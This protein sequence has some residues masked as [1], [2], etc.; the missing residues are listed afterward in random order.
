MMKPPYEVIRELESTN[1]RLDKEAI[2]RREAQAENSELF[3]GLRLALDPLMPFNVKKVGTKESDSREGNLPQE[4]FN[5]LCVDL[6][7][8][9]VTGHSA[10]NAVHEAMCKSGH[11]QWNDWYR[12]ILLKDLRAGISEKTVNKILKEQGRTSWMVPLFGGC[13][14]AYDGE[15]NQ[16]RLV[17]PKQVEVKLDGVRALTFVRNTPN[18]V[19]VDM[20]S[21]NGKKFENFTHIEDQIVQAHAELGNP[22]FDY[23]LDGEVMSSSFQDLM[24]QVYRKSDVQ[25]QDAVLH[26]FDMVSLY[27]WQTGYSTTPQKFRTYQLKD[28]YVPY[29]SKL[30]NISILDHEL[31]NLDTNEGCD[32]LKQLNRH[33]LD[34]DYEGLVLKD[35]EAGYQ[36][37][38]SY[39]WIKLKPVIEVSLTVESVVEGE[40]R[41]QGR[42]GALVC[43]GD[44]EG[45]VIHTNVGSGF[46][47]EQRVEYYTNDVVGSVAEI[48]ADAITMNQDG[49]YSLRFPRFLRFRGFDAGEKM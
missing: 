19:T 20:F 48:R 17:G 18:G 7:N 6:T 46:S 45:V 36:N 10:A 1:S 43:S 13:Q 22:P 23:V 8:R 33:A 35:P 4:E 26:A 44:G 3:A 12:K 30:H 42:L 29:E 11:S 25:A 21:R 32:R 16:K 34:N 9:E 38:R 41:N 15:K 24:K 5:Q 49:T 31:V 14:L 37:S 39:A 2:L 27:E 47:D 28:W 40:G